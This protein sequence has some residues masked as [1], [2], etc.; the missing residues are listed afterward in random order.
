M[1][2][3]NK[4][5]AYLCHV[6]NKDNNKDNLKTIFTISP[7]LLSMEQKDKM[8]LSLI[9]SIECHIPSKNNNRDNLKTYIH[10]Q[11]IILPQVLST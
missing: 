4:N 1:S 8:K 6:Q 3:I 11:T 2:P 10:K 7:Q 9:V 5:F